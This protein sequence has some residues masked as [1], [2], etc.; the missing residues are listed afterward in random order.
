MYYGIFDSTVHNYRII[1]YI[2]VKFYYSAFISFLVLSVFF[3]LIECYLKLI[4]IKRTVIKCKIII[5]T[6]IF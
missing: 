3:I 4:N 6:V 2:N 5:M 1:F